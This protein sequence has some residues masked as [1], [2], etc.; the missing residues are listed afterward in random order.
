MSFIFLPSF[1]YKKTYLDRRL[2]FLLFWESD[3]PVYW[4]KMEHMECKKLY[5][6]GIN[7]LL[8]A[9]LTDEISQ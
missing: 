8:P 5:S 2:W 7:E 6:K 1:F 9:R 4:G 3:K